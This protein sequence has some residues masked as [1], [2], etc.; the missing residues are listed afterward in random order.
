MTHNR[1][2]HRTKTSPIDRW[3]DDGGPPGPQEPAQRPTTR[4][5]SPASGSGS[6]RA[7]GSAP[8]A[9]WEAPSRPSSGSAAIRPRQAPD[10]TRLRMLV[11]SMQR[12]IDSI[13]RRSV[14]DDRSGLSVDFVAS[15][16]ELVE[17]LDLGPEPVVRACPVCHEVGTLTGT[18]CSHCWTPLIRSVHQRD[19]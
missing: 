15:F 5:S 16:D 8:P 17:Q 18:I 11:A 4:A 14:G 2:P 1:D 9:P 3:A 12:E 10:R 6:A 7:T 19:V 13:P